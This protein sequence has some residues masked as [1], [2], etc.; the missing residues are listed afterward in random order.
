ME[1]NTKIEKYF[2][3]FE[4]DKIIRETYFSDFNYKGTMIEVGGGLP[5]D[6][7]MSKHFKLNGWRTIIFE[8]NPKYAEEHRLAGN[9]IYEYA[10]SNK[11]INNSI[12]QVVDWNKTNLSFSS[13]K[14]KDGYLKKHNYT[15]NQLPITE[16]IVNVR[17]LDTI[18]KDININNLD[19][20]S[21]D[22]EGWELE[23]LQGFNIDF[24]KPKVVILENYLYDESYVSYMKTKNY[25][26]DNQI[27]YNYIFIKE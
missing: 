16:I 19:I 6:I 25:K 9:E 17:K 11:D 20:I 8:P 10:L 2:A 21:I 12:F 3:E 23:V 22:T 1:N 14:V 27:N 24:Y 15:V 7:S 18:L 5:T 26:L 13:I 4:T